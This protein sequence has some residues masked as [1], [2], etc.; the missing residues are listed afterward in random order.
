MSWPEI[1]SIL[2][3]E[4]SHLTDRP[5]RLKSLRDWK[6]YE[7]REAA[8]DALKFDES[9]HQ[10]I[11]MRACVQ[12]AETRIWPQLTQEQLFWIYARLHV[13]RVLV[14]FFLK[15]KRSRGWVIPDSDVDVP[16]RSILE[17]LL[18]MYWSH[19]GR[20]AFLGS[21]VFDPMGPF[22]PLADIPEPGI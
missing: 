3:G 11:V 20:V 18:V 9:T 6:Q 22:D 2:Q 4:L 15:S 14:R 16:V 1:L 19:Q 21:I 12:F 8:I 7:S 17:E 5:E 10:Q 13:A